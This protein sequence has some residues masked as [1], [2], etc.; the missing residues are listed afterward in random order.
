VGDGTALAPARHPGIDKPGV[1][2]P[3]VIGPQSQPLRH[4]GPVAFDERVRVADEIEYP[5]NRPPGT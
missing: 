4:A 2:L 5:G 3:A 1:P